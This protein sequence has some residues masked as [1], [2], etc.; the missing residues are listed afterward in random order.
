MT[1]SALF[2]LAGV[3]VVL[4][5]FLERRVKG[6]RYAESQRQGRGVLTGLDGDDRLARHADRVRKALLGHFTIVE[7]EPPYL[8]G[9]AVLIHRC[10]PGRIE[11]ERRMSRRCRK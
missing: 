1:T 7:T 10:Y 6:P 2:R 3:S 9:D 4:K 5:D 8:V 11:P